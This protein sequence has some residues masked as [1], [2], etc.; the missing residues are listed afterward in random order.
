MDDIWMLALIIVS[1]FV[2]VLV[3]AFVKTTTQS[4]TIQI[5]ACINPAEFN[6]DLDFGNGACQELTDS[7]QSNGYCYNGTIDGDTGVII[8]HPLSVERGRYISKMF[9]LPDKEN[10]KLVIKVANV[11]GKRPWLG[12]HCPNCDSGIFISITDLTDWSEHEIDD[13]V[14]KSTDGWIVKEYDITQFKGKPIMLDIYGYA[15]GN[16]KWNGE[17]T[18]VGYISIQ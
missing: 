2:G 1:F 18:A 5:P 7:I 12:D 9:M 3:S 15:A 8:I 13:F 17:W 10:L 4:N 6:S 16:E 11:V 14:I